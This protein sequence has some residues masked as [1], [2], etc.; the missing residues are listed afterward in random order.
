MPEWYEIRKSLLKA[1]DVAS[2][3][4]VPPY[5][6]YRGD[7]RADTLRKTVEN[8]FWGNMFTAHGQHYTELG[9]HH[10]TV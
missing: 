5:A 8:R 1:S 9:G 2:A 10:W 3:L 6:S 7:I 4:G